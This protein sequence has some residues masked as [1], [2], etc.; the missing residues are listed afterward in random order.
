MRRLGLKRLIILM[1]D[2]RVASTIIC[3]R[4]LDGGLSPTIANVNEIMAYEH[5]TASSGSVKG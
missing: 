1:G 5:Y 2:M 3:F 4:Y